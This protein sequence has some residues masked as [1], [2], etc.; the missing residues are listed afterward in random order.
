MV[1]FGSVRPAE[2][3]LGKNLRC[4]MEI[5]DTY[6][7]GDRSS[8]DGRGRG[9]VLDDLFYRRGL[10][11]PLRSASSGTRSFL[12]LLV[13]SDAQKSDRSFRQHLREFRAL[14][15]RPEATG[16][17][18]VQARSRAIAPTTGWFRG[19]RGGV[20]IRSRSVVVRIRRY[21]SNRSAR[22]GGKFK[23]NRIFRSDTHLGGNLVL[24][25]N[26]SSDTSSVSVNCLPR[27]PFPL[28][29]PLPLPFLFGITSLLAGSTVLDLSPLAYLFLFPDE[30]PRLGADV[31]LE[32]TS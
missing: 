28:A 24:V 27:F 17:D 19:R 21:Y 5:K 1:G 10:L 2:E 32:G 14:L 29:L 26:L 6:L 9:N 13:R 30:L 23:G 7:G 8:S 15:V 22:R 31:L 12:A 11:D 4:T 3:K 25:G 18:Q 16:V 20:V